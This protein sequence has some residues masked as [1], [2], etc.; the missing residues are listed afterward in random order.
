MDLS[1]RRLWKLWD[2]RELAAAALRTLTEELRRSRGTLPAGRKPSIPREEEDTHHISKNVYNKTSKL[3][4][5]GH[6]NTSLKDAQGPCRGYG[7]GQ[8]GWCLRIQCEDDV[9]QGKFHTVQCTL[10]VK[11]GVCG[12]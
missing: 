12:Q 10:A 6:L 5:S 2:K 11:Q 1:C 3:D 7:H 9:I 4:P 8:T